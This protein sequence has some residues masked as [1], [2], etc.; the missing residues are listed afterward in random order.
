MRTDMRV[1]VNKSLLGLVGLAFLLPAL[2][3]C[4]GT[5]QAADD[6]LASPRPVAAATADASSAMAAASPSSSM[7][8]A[9]TLGVPA[10]SSAGAGYVQAG[11]TSAEQG[12]SYSTS[13]ANDPALLVTEQ[14]ALSLSSS[15]L[16]TTGDGGHGAVVTQGSTLQLDRVR[17]ITAGTVALPLAT[18]QNAAKIEAT[19]SSVVSSGA[20][21]PC[22][23]AA[24]S[25][26]VSGGVYEA[27]RSE[28][29]VIEEDGSVTATSA[30]LSSKDAD[31]A[32]LLYR[33]TSVGKSNPATLTMTG[34]SRVYTNT[35]GSVFEVTNATGIITLSGVEV[36]ALSDTLLRAVAG[37]WGAVG[38]NGGQAILVADAQT[39]KGNLSADA[40]SSLDITLQNGSAL[41]GSINA[42][43]TAGDVKLA[44]DSTSTWKVTADSYLSALKLP[45]AV[46]GKTITCIIGAGHTVYYDAASAANTYLD[47]QTY[48]LSGGGYLKP[49]YP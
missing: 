21:S 33:T 34:G 48:R 46:A 14:A 38:A 10:T 23:Y 28:V 11:G 49:Y 22:L 12:R 17:V 30:A 44:L 42:E 40:L 26:E 9:E 19:N 39:L 31:Q 41:T 3:G 18:I 15:T 16:S 1:R 2:S 24:G 7:P 25:I 13:A 37:D 8:M 47:R 32:V 45:D 29:A 35:H 27:L 20:G 6:S 43:A 5:A 4:G 36:A